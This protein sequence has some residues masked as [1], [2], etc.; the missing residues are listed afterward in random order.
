MSQRGCGGVALLNFNDYDNV[1]DGAH[2]SGNSCVKALECDWCNA[3]RV[4]RQISRSPS[5]S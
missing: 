1:F 3:Q 4:L 2:F 5:L